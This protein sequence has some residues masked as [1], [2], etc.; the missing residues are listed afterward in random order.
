MASM[1]FEGL[2]KPKLLLVL[3]VH[4]SGTSSVARLMECLGAVPS[5]HP[6]K[7]LPNN[8]KGFFEDAD[9]LRF[10]E[11][12]LLPALGM[13]W[14]DLAPPDGSRLDDAARSSLLEKAASILQRNFHPGNPLSVLKDPRIGVL[15]PFWR[16]A[17]RLAGFEAMAV[18]SVRDPLSVA[19]SLRKR[20]G[21][22]IAQGSALYAAQWLTTLASA[23]GLPTA[24][25]AY[26]DIFRDPRSL[27][28]RLARQLDLPLPG[29]FDHRIEIYRSDFL[30][31]GLRHD[32]FTPTELDASADILPAARAVHR[33]LLQAADPATPFPHTLAL[34]PWQEWLKNSLPVLRNHDRLCVRDRELTQQVV[35]FQDEVG[36]LKSHIAGLDAQWDAHRKALEADLSRLNQVVADT[37]QHLLRQTREMEALTADTTDAK[38]CQAR[39]R[40]WSRRQHHIPHAAQMDEEDRVEEMRTIRDSPLFDPEYYLDAYPDV[41]EA[42]VDPLEHYVRHGWREG[43]NPSP[44]FDTRFY[45]RMY[46]DNDLSGVNPLRHY[47]ETGRRKGNH[48]TEDSRVQALRKQ[49]DSPWYRTRRRVADGIDRWQTFVD[50]R[51][52]VIPAL[53]SLSRKMLADGPSGIPAN[54]R[55]VL[56]AALAG[57]RLRNRQASDM[58]DPRRRRDDSRPAIPRD[59][60]PASDS[61]LF[62]GCDALRAGSQLV[63]LSILDWLHTHTSLDIRTI[64]LKGGELEEAYARYGPVIVWHDFTRQFPDPAARRDRLRLQLG[65]VDLVYGNTSLAGALY[66]D[67]EYTGAPFV[68]HIHELEQSIRA[69]VDPQSI[70]ELFRHTSRYIACSPPVARN[71]IDRHNIDEKRLDIIHEFIR[72]RDRSGLPDKKTMRRRLGI[73]DDKFLVVGCGTVYWRKGPDLFIETAIHLS[74]THG[75]RCRFLWIGEYYWDYDPLSRQIAPWKDLEAALQSNGLESLVGFFGASPDALDYIL[76]ADVFYL[77]SREDPFPLVCLEAAQCGVPVVCFDQAGGMPDFIGD[78]AGIVVPYL[79]TAAAAEAIHRLR[80]DSDLRR[81]LGDTAAAKLARRHTDD[82]TLPQILQLCRTEMRRPAPV[83]VIVPVYNHAP[84]LRQRLDGILG[85]SYRDI[86][87][88]I[89]DD[90]STDESLDIASTYTNDPRVR[91]I[92][93]DANS[94]SPFGQWKKGI[95]LAKGEFLWI[96]EGDDDCHPDFL[97]ELLPL[98]RDPDVAMAYADSTLVDELGQPL[99]SYQAYYES[100]D[101][102]H[103]KMDWMLPGSAEVDMGLGVKNTIPNVSAVLFRTRHIRSEMLDEIT[104]MHFSGDWYLYVQLAR[105]H[106]IAFR[107]KALNIHRK[108]AA[109]LTRQF[110]QSEEHRQTLLDEAR[111]IHDYVIRHFP[112]SPAFRQKLAHYLAEQIGALFPGIQPHEQ[113]RHYPV[114][115][116]LA[117]V[118]QRIQQERS[119]NRRMAFITTADVAHDGGSEQLW[120][121]TALRMAREGHAVIVLI[122]RW[123][124]EPYFFDSFRQA[125]IPI[126]FKED[127]PRQTLAAFRPDLVV[128]NIGDQDEGTP[129]YTACQALDLPYVILNHLTKEPRYWPIPTQGQDAVRTG[130]RLAQQVFFTSRNNRDLMERRLGC[131]IPHASLFHNPLFLQQDLKLRFPPLDGPLRLAMPSRLLT[132]HKGQ[133]IALQVFGWKKWRRRNIQLHLYGKGPDEASLR[134]TAAREKLH[135]VFFHE[136]EWQLPQPDMAAVWRDNHALLMTSFMEGMPLVLLNAMFHARVPIVTDIGGHSEVV[137]DNH[138]GFIAAEPTAEA[139]DEALERAWRNRDA[140][141]AIGQQAKA[142]MLRFAPEDPVGDLIAKL[143]HLT[144][145]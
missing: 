30:D 135:N 138:S 1:V 81:R 53:A 124:P 64:L 82:I 5:V 62:I 134:E 19:R 144:D 97:R 69:Y 59:S 13:R 78:E 106:R 45:L 136:P 143:L 63:L 60:L 104:G 116:R 67:L 122:R 145:N 9:V 29:D 107:G 28:V 55:G 98:L 79:D 119:V 121:Q 108:H 24:F 73:P 132:L 96:A 70:E 94:G 40:E 44:R 37:R 109:T 114:S 87:V 115:Q 52:G 42:N 34:E 83:T 32:T 38:E 12:Q 47:L 17:I 71:L 57:Q 31:A 41:R 110:N 111:Q 43:R 25:L 103:W 113:D 133:H 36:G 127:D 130:Y 137:E 76:A 21:F 112:L 80:T 85:Q 120:I 142:R 141:P 91:L 46:L 54:L 72:H 93:N 10:H 33:A 118:E 51:Q 6:V 95:E 88:I 27:L 35:N 23:E 65:R 58:D 74:R 101:I 16:E 7:P 126:A 84:F 125:G 105:H 48:P 18:C 75:R 123:T 3:G 2:P 68:S 139:V 66:P 86:E 11:T 140:W 4:R 61:I 100:L 89:L 99:G 77:P 14:H 90:A 56:T 49:M 92:R 129:W 50:R 15:L 102:S 117:A 131:A 128:V 8:P 39:L 26:D 20:D 22:P